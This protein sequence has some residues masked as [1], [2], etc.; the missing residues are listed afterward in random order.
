[1]K[2]WEL[3]SIMRTQPADLEN[4]LHNEQ[5]SLYR[6][7]L[8]NWSQIVDKQDRQILDAMVP[9]E[10]ARAAMTHLRDRFQVRN[11]Y[12]HGCSKSFVPSDSISALEAYINFGGTTIETTLEKGIAKFSDTM[13]LDNDIFEFGL[14]WGSDEGA[15]L[16]TCQGQRLRPL[17]HVKI[18][19]VVK[20]HVAARYGSV[21]SPD[22]ANPSPAV[23]AQVDSIVGRSFNIAESVLKYGTLQ[24]IERPQMNDES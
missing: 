4:I 17:G 7:W 14:A 2:F 18:I 15:V 24:Y 21:P 22:P 1:M 12:L 23:Q 11:G 13:T 6:E 20:Y 9:E 19:K 10:L 3:V 5:W 16:C 8:A